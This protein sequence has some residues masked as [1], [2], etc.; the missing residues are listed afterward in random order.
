M[1]FKLKFNKH[2]KKIRVVPPDDK[3]KGQSS[4][5]ISRDKN[6]KISKNFFDYE[7]FFHKFIFIEDFLN[8]QNIESFIFNKN[9]EEYANNYGDFA[10]MTKNIVF[11]ILVECRSDRMSPCERVKNG[12]ICAHR[13]NC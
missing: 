4:T 9:H 2:Y 10:K 1:F 8:Y 7:I 3:E 5:N 13:P 11:Y 6:R 12:R